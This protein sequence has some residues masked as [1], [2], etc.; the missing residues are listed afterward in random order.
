[1]CQRQH[2]LFNVDSFVM[3]PGLITGWMG[4]V[5]NVDS[6]P[7]HENL[8]GVR[9]TSRG[10]PIMQI[11]PKFFWY[12]YIR[13]IHFQPFVV[14]ACQICQASHKH[15]QTITWTGNWRQKVLKSHIC[16]DDCFQMRLGWLM[17]SLLENGGK[18]SEWLLLSPSFVGFIDL[19][20][21]FMASA[22]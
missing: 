14:L 20:E 1:M 4:L 6:A 16:T 19:D 7:R 2:S 3:H 22:M 10:N 5:M 15:C 18:K 11:Y 8:I 9:F 12:S 17:N 21:C 13:F